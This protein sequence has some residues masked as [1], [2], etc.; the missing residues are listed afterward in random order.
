MKTSLTIITLILLLMTTVCGEHKTMTSQEYSFERNQMV[1]QQIEARGIKDERVLKA[2]QKVPRHKFIPEK[3]RFMAYEDHPVSIGSG[4]TISQPY[5]VA[6]MTELLDLEKGE[7]VLEIGT[8]S[9]YQAAVLAELTD[10]VYSIEIIP[11][12]GKQAEATLKKLNYENVKVKIGDGYR[13]WPEYEPFDAIIVTAAPD[14]VPPKLVEQ[15]AEKGKMVIPVGDFFQELK[16]LTKKNGKVEE[17]IVTGVRFVP[18]TGE[19]M[20]K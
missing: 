12:L 8:G 2:M 19:A 6:L 9:G 11:E 18:M 14:H 10:R 4:Q 15:L 1:K 20:D 7:K 17:K 5:I 16:I 3:Y 13:G